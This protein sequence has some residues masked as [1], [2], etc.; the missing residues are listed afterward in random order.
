MDPV[1]HAGSSLSPETEGLPFTLVIHSEERQTQIMHKDVL[2]KLLEQNVNAFLR[3]QLASLQQSYKWLNETFDQLRQE[4]A[5]VDSTYPSV[6]VASVPPRKR[7]ALSRS[8]L[9][10]STPSPYLNSICVYPSKG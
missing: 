2:L 3:Q 1:V 7:E 8:L 6:L 10:I 4:F 5:L 9:Q